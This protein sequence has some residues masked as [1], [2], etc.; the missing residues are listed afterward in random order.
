[1][2]RISS[3]GKLYDFF[4]ILNVGVLVVSNLQTQTLV[5]SKDDTRNDG[6]LSIRLFQ[7]L[8]LVYWPIHRLPANITIDFHGPNK[9]LILGEKIS[10]AS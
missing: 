9:T 1:M 2:A 8:V 6:A 7:T 5:S 4:R 3:I 10:I